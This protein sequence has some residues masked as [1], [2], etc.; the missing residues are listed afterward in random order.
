MPLNV[1]RTRQHLQD[2]DFRRLFVEELGW[3]N[4]PHALKSADAEAKGGIL[5]R[6]TPVA[7]LSAIHVFE[8]AT[9]LGTIPDAKARAAIH[10][11]VSALAAENL[12]IFTDA[13]RTQSLWYWVKREAGKSR[14][15]DHLYVKGQPGD[16]FLSKLAALVVDISELDAKGNI[17]LTEVARRLKNALDVERVTK[18]FFRDFQT[19][20]LA[21][22]E[23]IEG[24]PDARDRRWYASVL[25][26][27][28]MF[29]WFL[30]KKRFLDVDQNPSGDTDYLTRKFDTSAAAKK[31]RFFSHFLRDLFFEGFAK[32]ESKRAPIGALPLGDIP[33]LNGGLFLPHGIETRLEGAAFAG[34]PYKKIRIPDAAFAGLFALFQ[35]YSWSLDDTPGGNDKEINPDVLGYIFEKYINQKEF[36]AYYTRPEI[37]EYLCEQTIHQLVLDAAAKWTATATQLHAAGVTKGPAPRAYE[38]VGDLLLHADGPLCQHLLQEILPRLS[39]LDPAC[40]SGAFLVAALKTLLNLTTG[41]IGRC[42]GLGHRP[43]LQWIE[44]EQSKHRAPQAYW[45]KKKIITENLYGVDLMEEAVEIA[46][47]RL[48]LTLVA[49]AEARDQLEPLPNI[50]FNLL[51]GNSLIG[52]LHVDPAGFDAGKSGRAGEQLRATLTHET[53]LGLTVESATAPTQKEKQAEWLAQ[54]RIKK[55]AALLAEKNRLVTLYRKST[56][57]TQDLAVLRAEIDA[58][59]AAARDVL[60][61]QLLNEFQG[62][63]IEFSQATW[64]TKKQTED[65]PEKRPLTLDDIRALHPFHW[66]YEFDEIIVGRGGFDAIITNPPWEVFKPNAKEFFAQFS[67]LVSKKNMSIQ[68]F[69]KAQSKLLQDEETSEA[70]LKYL[71]GFPHLSAYFRS[72]AQFRNQIAVVNGKKAGTDVNLYRLFLEQCSHLLRTGGDCGILLPTGVYTDLGSKQLREMLFSGTRIG[73]L[74]G[75]SNERFI[76]EGIHHAF[77]FAIL[78]FGKGGQTDAFSAAFRIHPYEAVKPELLDS[79]LRDV[80]EH[81]RMSVPL[82]RQISPDSL[83]VPEFKN[84]MDAALSEKFMAH[85]LLGRSAVGTTHVQFAREFDM[86]QNEGSNL[87][88]TTRASGLVPLIEGKMIWHFDCHFAEPRFWIEPKKLRKFLFGESTEILSA[89]VFRLVFR[90]Q[91]SSTNERTLVTT[92]IPPAFH[93]DNMASLIVV[94]SAGKPTITD[95]EQIFLCAVLNSLTLDYVVRQRVTTNLNFFYLYQL[96]VPRLTAADPAFRPLVERAARL[97]G[98][99]EEFDDL[100]KEIFGPRATHRTHGERTPEG[101]A[102]LRAEIDAQVAHLYALTEPE[103]THILSTFPLVPAPVKAAALAEYRHLI[104]HPDDA[105]VT[106]II[107]AG[108]NNHV[109]FKEAAAWNAF[110]RAKDDN[111]RLK[112]AEAVAGFMN[113]EGGTLI[114]GVTDAGKVIGIEDDI[115]VADAKKSNLDGYE[116][117]LRNYLR[118]ALGGEKATFFTI[119]FHMIR[120]KQVCRIGVKSTL[121]PVFLDG[122]LFVRTGNQTPQLNAQEAT[123][124]QKHHWQ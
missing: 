97:V 62:L 78:T 49:S 79:F 34:G 65:K 110:K 21:F 106:K 122:Q 36:G 111:M 119:S 81:V 85:P 114:L 20:H 39:L 101:R 52:L 113:A 45:L 67:E 86:T 68:D 25:L 63:G 35:Q 13:A 60:D 115:R 6:R 10:A 58:Q 70:W 95:Q 37:T 12:L 100:L 112:I 30:Q 93:A 47:L 109:E 103:F 61:R 53:E 66:A 1:A 117:F 42:Q 73:A 64:D 59:K 82:I 24:I 91:A 56:S 27:R 9:P 57:I 40:G 3:N 71:S 8:I 102:K 69:E 92:I 87:A 98:T 22:L 17:P 14:P 124:Y 75:L 51:P 90:R 116:L 107:A 121:M 31:D 7:V 120:E 50:E 19:Q 48:F 80:S 11:A 96:P 89:D 44:H 84:A 118:A 23:L 16:L 28:L 15:R 41:L 83:S 94:D 2:F 54:E 46:K 43:V 55:Y 99:T 123:A 33:Y 105:V 76:F 108:E 5:F 4:P 29:V 77:K 74:F 104:P 38:T 18:A 72:A 88:K 32:P 26:N